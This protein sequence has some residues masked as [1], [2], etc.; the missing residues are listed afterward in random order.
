MLDRNDTRM[1]GVILNK[2]RK[3]HFKKQQLNVHLPPISK[4]IQV[5]RTR[6]AEQCWRSKDKLMC[7]VLLWNLQHMVVPVLADQHELIYNSSVR[8]QDVIWKTCRE[9]WMI[10]ADGVRD[11]GN[12]CCQRDLMMMMMMMIHINTIAGIRHFRHTTHLS[13]DFGK[14]LS[15]VVWED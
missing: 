10:G 9:R 13:K 7:D 15:K 12:T 1:R 5:I 2:S 14:V 11:S 3:Q 4:S 8:T 6:H